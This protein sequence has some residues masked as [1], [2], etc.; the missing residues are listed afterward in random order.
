MA[1]IAAA[2]HRHGK[3]KALS[4]GPVYFYAAVRE[5]A[6]TEITAVLIWLRPRPTLW[7]SPFGS[8]RR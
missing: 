2:L 7:E 4:R 1:R 8:I 5:N 3:A 6:G